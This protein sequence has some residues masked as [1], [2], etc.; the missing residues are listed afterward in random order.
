MMRAAS[1]PILAL[2]SMGKWTR[3]DV[4]VPCSNVATRVTIGPV[5]RPVRITSMERFAIVSAYSS[6][7]WATT[8]LDAVTAG[9]SVCTSGIICRS[10][11]ATQIAEARRPLRCSVGRRSRFGTR[12]ARG[13]VLSEFAPNGYQEDEPDDRCHDDRDDHRLGG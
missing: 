1:S 13:H 6:A 9:A 11:S 2:P 5:P 3:V 4:T 10:V 7:S 12:T 8:S